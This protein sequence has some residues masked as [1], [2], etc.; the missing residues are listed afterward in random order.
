MRRQEG[1]TLGSLRVFTVGPPF[2]PHAGDRGGEASLAEE[3]RKASGAEG[4]ECNMVCEGRIRTILE[5]K[6]VPEGATM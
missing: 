1:D 5:M 6:K 2:P 3:K 4:G